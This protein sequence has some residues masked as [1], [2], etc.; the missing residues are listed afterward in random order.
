ML[1]GLPDPLL[2]ETYGNSL[3][4]TGIGPM[5]AGGLVILVSHNVEE[6]GA[7]SLGFPAAWRS[8]TY[9]LR[10]HRHRQLRRRRPLLTG[11]SPHA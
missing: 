9:D 8:G 1:A 11:G 3:V 10:Q 7:F 2:M 4:T 6:T 5:V